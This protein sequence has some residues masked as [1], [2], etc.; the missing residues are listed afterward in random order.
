MH[1]IS[2]GVGK[3]IPFLTFICIF[4]FTFICD[5]WWAY[6]QTKLLL[7]MPQ[8]LFWDLRVNKMI[9]GDDDYEYTLKLKLLI[10]AECRSEGWHASGCSVTQLAS[11]SDS[12][13]R[14]QPTAIRDKLK[15]V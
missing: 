7:N 2:E 8:K 11:Y 12:L 4:F 15:R 3:D 10:E 9:N 13:S 6:H 1:F 14:C 5:Y